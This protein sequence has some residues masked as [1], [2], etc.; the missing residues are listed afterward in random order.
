MYLNS[1]FQMENNQISRLSSQK[2]Q[3]MR[4]ELAENFIQQSSDGQ[5]AAQDV[6]LQ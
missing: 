1:I 6:E 5:S 3:Q 4:S 2:V